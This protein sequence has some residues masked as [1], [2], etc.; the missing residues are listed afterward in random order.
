MVPRGKSVMRGADVEEAVGARFD[1]Q[2]LAARLQED[3]VDARGVGAV[4]SYGWR[5]ASSAVANVVAGHGKPFSPA[6][7][8]Q[9]V[10][11]RAL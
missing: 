4:A 6:G 11:P 5:P 1:R 10:W 2:Q 3:G 8:V 9:E 7:S